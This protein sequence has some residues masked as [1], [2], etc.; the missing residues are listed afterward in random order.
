M[1]AAQSTARPKKPEG[2]PLYPHPGGQWVKKVTCPKS[3][4]RKTIYCGPWNDHA[5]A[6]NDHAGALRYW[7]SVKDEIAAGIFPTDQDALTVGNLCGLCHLGTGWVSHR[8]Q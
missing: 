6:W 3:G 4:K 2:S 7:L 8:F 1:T 5:G